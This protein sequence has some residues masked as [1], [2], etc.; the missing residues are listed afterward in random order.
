MYSENAKKTNLARSL[1][2]LVGVDIARGD[3]KAARTNYEKALEMYRSRIIRKAN[4][5]RKPSIDASLQTKAP[6]TWRP[7][8]KIKR[9]RQ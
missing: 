6:K 1:N 8:R 2:N 7:L 9:A 3:Y 4:R 5:E